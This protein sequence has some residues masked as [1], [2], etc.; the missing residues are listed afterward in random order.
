MPLKEPA[1]ATTIIKNDYNTDIREQ[2]FRFFRKWP[3][4]LGSLI[5]FLGIAYIYMRYAV[6]EYYVYSTILID[7]EDANA[8]QLDAIKDIGL[9]DKAP[10]KIENEIQIL[11]SRSIMTEV[12][13][14]LNLNVQHYTEGNVIKS[15]NYPKSILEVNF[16][17]AD[18]TFYNKSQ[19]FNIHI[20][21]KLEFEINE[22]D[23]EKNVKHA[24][25]NSINTT[26][27]KIIITPDDNFDH[28]IGKKIE[29]RIIPVQLVSEYYRNKISIEPV[30]KSPSVL[31]VSLND[32]VEEKAKDIVNN[33]ISQYNLAEQEDNMKVA[34]KTS[35]FI[36][37]RIALIT[38]DLS[39]VD[40]DAANFRSSRGL[41]IDINSQS[42]RIA[43]S[44]LQADKEIA[45]Q[46]AELD[47]VTSLKNSIGNRS[48]TYE[49]VPYNA[50]FSDP[51]VTS[52][53][54]E[55]NKLVNT[56]DRLLEN[57]TAQNPLVINVDNQLGDLRTSMLASLSNLEQTIKIRLKSLQSQ[58]QNY[59]S[60]MYAAPK[61][62]QALNEIER[63]AGIKEQLYLY[64]LQ[65][66]EEA[67]ISSGV[68]SENARVIDP[69]ITTDSGSI[70]PPRKVIY[71]GAFFAALFLPFM[72]IYIKGLLNVKV[73]SREDLEKALST[74]IIGDIPKTK[75][76]SPQIISKTDR[77]PLAESFR[78]LKTNL[79]FLMADMHS[80]KGSTIFL[81]STISGEGKTFI[82]ANLAKVLAASGK[83]WYSWAAI[84]EIQNFMK[85]LIYL[86]QK[87][88]WDSLLILLIKKRLLAISF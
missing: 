8:P 74:P 32:P 51:G 64:L 40:S 17:D 83:K 11:R 36:N 71:G 75:S 5:L 27:G 18:S 54:S 55:Y 29:I 41:G 80:E 87:I 13:K 15:E 61:Q 70:S 49:I 78:I 43:E 28:Y 38:T 67:E 12:V 7:T 72:I 47:I 33:L 23:D 48:D 10:N 46:S 6:P 57:S 20:L 85:Y 50:G 59:S 58:N 35:S 31:K 16:I 52:L 45:A 34:K 73:Q 9:I 65:K 1:Q 30:E 76:K 63:Q 60:K 68:T 82:S 39:E 62:V 3:W 66:R 77:S 79:N 2:L 42:Q 14:K 56:R 44:N 26:I 22:G 21:S 84:S 19:L 88:L 81:T 25:G 24:F 37:D 4:F 69:A 86:K 53:V